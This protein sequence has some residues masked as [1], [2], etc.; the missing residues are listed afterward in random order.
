[1]VTA[2]LAA[3]LATLALPCDF[4]LIH[5]NTDDGADADEDGSETGDLARV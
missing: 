2:V 5:A 4:L 3:S 1:M